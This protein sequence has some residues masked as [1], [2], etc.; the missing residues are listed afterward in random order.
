MNQLV[1]GD[2]CISTDQPPGYTS[3]YEWVQIGAGQYRLL[4]SVAVGTTETWKLYRLKPN[5]TI[6]AAIALPPIAAITQ[7]LADTHPQTIGVLIRL[8]QDKRQRGGYVIVATV[9]TNIDCWPE[10]VG[11]DCSGDGAETGLEAGG[12]LY[13]SIGVLA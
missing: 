5:Q 3:A 2:T 1:A 12:G 10:L 11:S 6:A 9:P 8:Q 13:P 7:A 4:A